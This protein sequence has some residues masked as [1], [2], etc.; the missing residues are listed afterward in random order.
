MAGDF[1]TMDLTPVLGFQQR[2]P[3]APIQ[4]RLANLTPATS[5]FP[6]IIRFGEGSIEDQ[7]SKATT[8][9]RIGR[10]AKW[11]PT[12]TFGNSKPG[13]APLVRTGQYM[14][15]WLGGPGG[16]ADVTATS[17]AVGVSTSRFPQASVFQKSVPTLIPVTP[18]MRIYLGLNKGVWLKRSTTFL[19]VWP[20][21]FSVNPII[22]RRARQVLLNYVINGMATEYR[23]GSFSTAA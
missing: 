17:A 13:P 12:R 11:P 21:A 8:I 18:K 3:T 16:F 14:S 1:I 15:A 20:R 10:T 22:T 5:T 19:T 7:Q 2:G 23:P 6:K 4:A 9:G